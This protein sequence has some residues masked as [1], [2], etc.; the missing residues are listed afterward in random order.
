MDQTVFRGLVNNLVRCCREPEVR[1]QRMQSPR[2]VR[3]C[4]TSETPRRWLKGKD[5]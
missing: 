1:E 2:G 4:V 3:L 5:V